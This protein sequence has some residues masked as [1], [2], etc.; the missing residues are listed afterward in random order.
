[1]KERKVLTLGAGRVAKPLVD[2]FIDTCGFQV[3]VADMVVSRAEKLVAGRSL[4]RAV[5]WSSHQEE[6]LDELAREHDIVV[7]LIPSTVHVP[8][9]RSCLRERKNMVTAAYET[10]PIRALDTEARERGILIFNEI[11]ED[12]G[13]DHL[14]TQMI[15]DAIRSEGG[16]VTSLRSFGAGIPSFRS[17]NNPMGYK[18]SWDPRGLFRS[19]LKP[20]RYFEDGTPVEV[21]GGEIFA[22]HWLL[23]IEDLGTFEVYPNR[24]CSRY[25]EA[26]GLDE[27]ATFYRG[28]LRY[29]GYCNNMRNLIAL[30]LL[31]SQE[32]L[33]LGGQTYRQFMAFLVGSADATDVEGEVA[34]YLSVDTNA[35]I[36]NRLRWLGLFDDR[37][38]AV[39]KGSRLDVLLDVMLE[40]M[41][42]RPHETDMIIVHL[43]AVA[44]F[45]DRR[46]KRTAT[47][48]LEGIPDGESAMSRAVGLTTAVTTRLIL[49]GRI[50]ATGVKMPPTVPG[51]YKPVLDELAGYGLEF[52]RRR[53]PL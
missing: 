16:R 34:R 48:V 31:D 8:V 11:G 5:S 41:S 21:P 12:P 30:G 23:D 10:A 44:G 29:S 25:L 6:R 27:K 14:G 53:V 2:Y 18:F 38:L 22:R 20:A 36:I 33:D 40:K 42:Y 39:E 51:L 52:E 9:A 4:G 49:E 15:V 37:P 35:D 17:N 19:A 43:E 26:F 3:T 46:E 45:A 24:D 1:M 50:K 13:L 28:L 7:A 47:L 32:E